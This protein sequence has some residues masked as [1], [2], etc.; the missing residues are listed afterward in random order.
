M[1]WKFYHLAKSLL[2][3]SHGNIYTATYH[4]VKAAS[5]KKRSSKYTSKQTPSKVKIYLKGQDKTQ[6]IEH[7]S[8]KNGTLK[9]KFYGNE[10]IYTYSANNYSIQDA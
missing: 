5:W 3:L 9:V 2:S 6:N 4:G 1:F 7:F 8:I 10:T